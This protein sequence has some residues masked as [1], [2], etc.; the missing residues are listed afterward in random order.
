MRLDNKTQK[1]HSVIKYK[2]YTSLLEGR[3]TQK[4]YN[5][6]SEIGF[7]D[8]IKSFFGGGV[9]VS[10]D[11]GK[12]FSN[13]VAQRQLTAAKD[14]I[15]KAVQDLRKVAGEAGVDEDTINEFLM[16][17]FKSADIDPA[18]VASAGKGGG[19]DKGGESAA[20][21]APSGTP[22]SA[23]AIEKNPAVI[24]RIVADVT[25]KD[26]EKVAAEIEKKKPDVAALSAVLGNAIGKN[27]GVDG[28]IVTDVVKALI[29]KGHL[30][31]ENGNRLTLRGLMSFINEV[32]E[33]NNQYD[34]MERW[35]KLAGVRTG[36][37]L[38]GRT[39]DILKD[40]KAKKIKSVEELE[41]RIKQATADGQGGQVL[42]RK[43][44]IMSAFKE[45]NPDVK[46]QDE[47]KIDTAIQDAGKDA[48]AGGDKKEISP[49]DQKKAEEVKKEFG[50]AFKDVR[51]VIDP[52]KVD[53]TT[54]AKVIGAIDGFKSVSIAA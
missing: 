28:K 54:L 29:D 11:L 53:D 24:T 15:T 22:V 9:D 44:E 50:P 18:E 31:L 35:Q 48:P 13:K 5:M 8:K 6:L 36:V 21:E 19:E 16:G 4:E 45:I 47:K 42:K 27:V 23:A 49:E 37:M 14:A 26:E 32:N 34:L 12:L 3:I 17:V 38:E 2:A 39:G 7:L 52:K 40:I 51:A 43:D 46:P 10:K 20:G 30:K 1:L 25:G 41:A 33:L